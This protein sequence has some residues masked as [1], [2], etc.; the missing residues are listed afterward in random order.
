MMHVSLEE[1]V[2]HK[3]KFSIRTLIF[4][5]RLKISAFRFNLKYKSLI[6]KNDDIIHNADKELKLLREERK[7]ICIK[8]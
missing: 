4:K 3:P 6:R 1:F 8:R 5:I 2:G 7:K